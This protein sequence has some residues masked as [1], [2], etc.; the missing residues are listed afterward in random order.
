MMDKSELIESIR[1][2]NKTA[3]PEFLA[4]FSEKQLRAYLEHLAELSQEELT[5]AS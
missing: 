4:K 1:E 3:K 5:V 2:I